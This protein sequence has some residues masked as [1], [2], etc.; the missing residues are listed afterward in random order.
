VTTAVTPSGLGG[1][2][3]TTSTDP[4]FEFD[5]RRVDV[6]RWLDIGQRGTRAVRQTWRATVQSV[7][8]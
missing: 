8:S 1:M 2:I 6:A 3:E 7:S 4:L 5:I